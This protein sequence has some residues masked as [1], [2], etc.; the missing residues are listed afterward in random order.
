MTSSYIKELN[1]IRQRSTKAAYLSLTSGFFVVLI[2]IRKSV[3]TVELFDT[4]ISMP[5]VI[6]CITLTVVSFIMFTSSHLEIKHIYTTK[7]ESL[8][9][10]REKGI[11]SI[12]EYAFE[13]NAVEE[14]FKIIIR[15]DL[16]IH[17]GFHCM[18]FM[19]ICMIVGVIYFIPFYFFEHVLS[20]WFLL[21]LI[22]LVGAAGDFFNF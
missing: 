20:P 17:F 18:L 7:K 11:I 21:I 12:D 16:I 14:D 1:D 4:G 13:L 2:I 3:F 19:F 5:V 8:L 9:N 15:P 10:K 6:A 22:P